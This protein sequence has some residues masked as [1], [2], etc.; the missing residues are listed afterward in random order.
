MHCK[1]LMVALSVLLIAA[2]AFGEFVLARAANAH[3]RPASAPLGL[4]YND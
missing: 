3:T 4:L 1:A 2:P